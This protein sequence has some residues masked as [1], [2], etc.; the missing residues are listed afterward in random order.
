[1]DKSFN[2]AVLEHTIT[3]AKED[4]KPTSFRAFE[5][6]TGVKFSQNEELVDGKDKLFVFSVCF[7]GF[8]VFLYFLLYLFLT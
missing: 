8:A 1:M 5:E 7:I 3:T 2:S 4:R 6:S